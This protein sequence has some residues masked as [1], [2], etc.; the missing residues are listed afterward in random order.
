MDFMGE[1]HKNSKLPK[2]INS[3][4]ITLVPKVDNPVH[5]KDYKPI[6][7]M[8]VCIKI[9]S[10]VLAERIKPTIL[11]IVGDIQSTFSGG[12]NIQ[13]SILIANEVLES[14]KKNEKKEI[15][16][17]LDFENAFDNVNMIYLFKMMHLMSFSIKW[18]KWI[19]E[20]LSSA[21]FGQIR[22]HQTF[23]L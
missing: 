11:V 23:S 5:L 18:V 3:S 17:K 2:G 15:I 22:S 21:S 7:L 4:F 6:S 16:I 20:C 13:Y 9:L 8:A 10:K 12:K 14:W 1:F 19:R